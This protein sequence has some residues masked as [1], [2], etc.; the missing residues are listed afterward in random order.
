MF[1]FSKKDKQKL[2]LL[3]NQEFKIHNKLEKNAIERILYSID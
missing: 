3:T 2:L 1:N